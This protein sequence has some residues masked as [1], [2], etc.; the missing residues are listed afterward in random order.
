MHTRTLTHTRVVSVGSY[1][2]I[3]HSMRDKL[4]V[5]AALFLLTSSFSVLI[6][7]HF[8]GLK[9]LLDY[10]KVRK[11]AK[12]PH[13]GVFHKLIEFTVPKQFFW[14]FYAILVI[15]VVIRSLAVNELSIRATLLLIQGIRRLIEQFALFSAS[16]KS[17]MHISHYL[18]GIAF[19]FFQGVC[20]VEDK[21]ISGIVIFLIGWTLQLIFHRTL[22]KTVKYNI[23][24]FPLLNSHRSLLT[25]CPHYG[26]EVIIYLGFFVLSFDLSSLVSTTPVGVGGT[27]VTFLT[28]LWVFIS[29]SVA[30]NQS[31]VYYNSIINDKGACSQNESPNDLYFRWKLIPLI[32]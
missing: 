9:R 2:D 7:K 22:A 27:V 30:G 14:H 24:E 6:A 31:R 19:Y 17:R 20:N 4:N 15:S 23:P 5:L 11:P 1:A 8:T 13:N 10:G 3:A 25:A 32:I 29:L 12:D 16:P 18:V 28:L 26:A 21:H